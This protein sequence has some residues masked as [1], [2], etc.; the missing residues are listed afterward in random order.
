MTIEQDLGYIKFTQ[1]RILTPTE[2]GTKLQFTQTE[3]KEPG[4]EEMRKQWLEGADPMEKKFRTA[5]ADEIA[6]GNITLA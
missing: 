2:T 1:S 5:I 3:P 4:A 6:S